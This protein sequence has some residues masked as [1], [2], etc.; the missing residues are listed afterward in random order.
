MRVTGDRTWLSVETLAGKLVFQGLLSAGQT[1]AFHDGKGL[2]M[3]IGN[4]PAVDLVVDGRDIGAPK[5]SGSVAH[6]TIRPGGDVQ[7]A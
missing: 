2:R 6:V 7:Y 5:S 3:V 1:R 4:A